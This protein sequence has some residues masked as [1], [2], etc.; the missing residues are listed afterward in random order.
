MAYFGGIFFANMGGGG[1][2][3]YFQTGSIYPP[4]E[5]DRQWTENGPEMHRSGQNGPKMDP[6][7]PKMGPE[8]F[9]H[10]AKWP[11][12][13]WKLARLWREPP[14]APV[15]RTFLT[16]TPE[17]LRVK[18]FLPTTGATGKR[19]LWCGCP[20]SLA[21]TSM[22]R[23]ALEETLP[24]KVC[25]H[26]LVPKQSMGESFSG[27]AWGPRGDIVEKNRHTPPIKSRCSHAPLLEGSNVYTCDPSR[28]LQE[29]PG[30]PPFLTFWVYSGTFWRTP[31]KTLLRHF[32][33]FWARSARGPHCSKWR[34]GLQAPCVS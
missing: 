14:E 15:E 32:F 25:V 23:R 31:K 6:N 34:L 12:S 3:N 16:L 17:C 26:L 19:T 5:T 29:F 7:R 13:T 24:W 30:P 21:R 22:T 10:A 33:W 18:K 9:F 2:Q 28:H 27:N 8:F 4:A 1:G 11:F 20:R